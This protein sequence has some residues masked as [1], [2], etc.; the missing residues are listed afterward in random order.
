[1]KHLQKLLLVSS[2]LVLPLHADKHI[3]VNLSEQKAYAYENK[4]IVFQGKISSGKK[5]NETPNGRFKILE[6]K[7]KHKSNLY[8]VK[9]DGSRGGA[10]MPYMMRLTNTGYA[11][12]LGYTPK[13]AASHGCVRLKN[14]FAQKMYRWAAV[15]TPVEIKGMAPKR[16]FDSRAAERRVSK[17][18][19]RIGSYTSSYSQSGVRE[20]KYVKGR[21]NFILQ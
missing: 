2:F 17:K 6:K 16:V 8:P 21:Y 5:G 13:Y 14:K 3:V 1:M 18:N 7:R 4:E 15:G 10:K 11:M 20:L 19:K 12:H 9:K